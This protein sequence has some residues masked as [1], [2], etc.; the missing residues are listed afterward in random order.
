MARK[1]RFDDAQL[2]EAGKPRRAT[3]RREASLP[4]GD[5]RRHERAPM[6]QPRQDENVQPSAIPRAAL[7]WNE[8]QVSARKL[9]TTQTRLGG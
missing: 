2:E 7:D 8:V 1:V 6:S 4:I 3:K 9:A 5:E